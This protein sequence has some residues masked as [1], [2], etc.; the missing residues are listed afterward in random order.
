[1][2]ALAV[3]SDKRQAVLPNVPTAKEAGVDN[4]EVPIWYGI[5][6]SAG[7]PRE[8]VG[9]L[10]REIGRALAA[11]DLRERLTT[12][13]IEPRPN[14]PEQFAA[15]IK[16]ETVRYAQVIKDSGIKPQ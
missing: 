8:I 2:R 9:R 12:A 7:T 1:M 13:G 6:T 11:P 16:S 15:F 10:N 5:L 14:T 3:L 4:Y